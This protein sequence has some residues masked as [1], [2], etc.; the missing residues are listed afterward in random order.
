MTGLGVK[1]RTFPPS[2]NLIHRILCMYVKSVSCL[3]EI[4]PCF[5]LV[6]SCRDYLNLSIFCLSL[7]SVKSYEWIFHALTLHVYMYTFSSFYL[8]MNVI[9]LSCHESNL[10]KHS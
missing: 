5:Q 3:W 1:L 9:I 6:V 10:L 2:G 8:L 7:G 4:S